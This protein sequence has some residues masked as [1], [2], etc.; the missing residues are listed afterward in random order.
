MDQWNEFGIMQMT[1]NSED[2]PQEKV[3]TN[4]ATAPD[5]AR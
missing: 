2:P 1:I 4:P 5:A 3:T